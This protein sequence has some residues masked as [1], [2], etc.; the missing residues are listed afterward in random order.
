MKKSHGLL[1][2]SHWKPMAAKYSTPL[3]AGPCGCVEWGGGGGGWVSGD[4]ER[5]HTEERERKSGTEG[6]T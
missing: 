4:E 5:R 1:K 2:G 6:M 3:L